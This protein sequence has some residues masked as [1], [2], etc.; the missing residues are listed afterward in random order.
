MTTPCDIDPNVQDPYATCPYCGAIPHAPCR[1]DELS[2]IQETRLRNR[3]R[4]AAERAARAA[5]IAQRA[6]R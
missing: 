2:E 1:G 5:N 3:L 4:L 6:K